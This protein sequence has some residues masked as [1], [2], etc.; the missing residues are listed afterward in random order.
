MREQQGDAASGA[1]HHD[2]SRAFFAERADISKAEIVVPLTE[3]HGVTAAEV[4]AAWA[5][6]RYR[7]AVDE[8]IR[9]AFRAGATG[10]PATAWP[11]RPAVV[12]MMPPE[13]LV[14]ALQR[15]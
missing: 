7:S 1:F 10:V 11:N 15:R 14:A 8:F 12:G 5:A 13:D 9:Q 4:E 3:R 2:V 6:R